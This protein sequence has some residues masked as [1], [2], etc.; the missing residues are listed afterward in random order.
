MEIN[1]LTLNTLG[2]IFSRRHLKYF[3]YF[4]P[5]NRIWHFMQLHE[6]SNPVFWESI[7]KISSICRLLRESPE[8]GIFK[9]ACISTYKVDVQVSNSCCSCPEAQTEQSTRLR[10]R[11]ADIAVL[12]ASLEKKPVFGTERADFY[13]ICE[14]GTYT[15]QFLHHAGYILTPD[16][17]R[18]RKV[19]SADAYFTFFC[20]SCRF[21]RA[22]AQ[23]NV[24]EYGAMC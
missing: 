5:E 11:T 21:S 22:R 19:L 23:S 1:I 20:C 12:K 18:M 14:N 4:F 16:R 10:R 2:N 24:T 3:S 8:M 7:R 6:M 9:A 13:S 15:E 17:L